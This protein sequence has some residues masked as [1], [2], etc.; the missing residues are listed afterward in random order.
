MQPIFGTVPAESHVS[1]EH[2]LAFAGVR[3][4]VPGASL[5]HGDVVDQLAVHK[6]IIRYLRY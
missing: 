1:A 5:R 4:G 6:N 3:F 2:F